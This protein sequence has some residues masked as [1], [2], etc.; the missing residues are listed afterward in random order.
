[1]QKALI[2]DLD[3]VLINNELIWEQHKKQLYARLFGDEVTQRLGSTLGV[4]MDTIYERAVANGATVDKQTL[5]D[6]FFD[7]AKTVYKE[8]PLTNN[9]AELDAYL[10]ANSYKVA[11]VSASPSEW[12]D[13][14][15]PRLA[16]KSKISTV[17]SLWEIE[18]LRHKPHPDGYLEAM[19]QLGVTPES[20]AILEDSNGGIESAKASGAFTIGFQEN[21]VDGYEQI[22]AD[23]YAKDVSAVIELLK[24]FERKLGSNQQM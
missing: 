11:I 4:N 1:M 13:T 22:G 6:A 12:I 16:F 20:T 5:L 21:V 17:I 7:I 14:V 9:L 2:F 15:I 24:A 3:G 10:V 8:A 19:K 23:E 18:H